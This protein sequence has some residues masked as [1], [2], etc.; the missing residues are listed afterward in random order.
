MKKEQKAYQSIGGPFREICVPPIVGA[1]A[2]GRLMNTR[3][4][5]SQREAVRHPKKGNLQFM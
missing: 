3:T 1:F 5:Q 2:A 4:A